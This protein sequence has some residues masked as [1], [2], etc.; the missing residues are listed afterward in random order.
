MKG[1]QSVLRS[2]IE[3]EKAGLDYCYGPEDR[4]RLQEML[5]EGNRKL[6]TNLYYL[7]E[8]DAYDLA[9]AGEIFCRY[10]DGFQSESVRAYLLPQIIADKVPGC[11]ALLLRLYRH[12]QSSPEFLPVNGRLPAHIYVRYDNAFRKRKPKKLEAELLTLAQDPV[13]FF[14]L[15]F[16]ME[17][18]ARW[19]A[20]SM[21]GLLLAYGSG[22]A[23]LPAAFRQGLSE[24][25]LAFA[26]RQIRFTVIACSSYFPTEAVAELV[27][28]FARQGDPDLCQA[29]EKA[30]RR[31][32]RMRRSGMETPKS[33]ALP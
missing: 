27:E 7:A 6:G 1:M 16:T 24:R 19:R 22:K 10:I 31:A 18:L 30:R 15:P 33:C 32:W 3:R 12:F 23:Q 4:E 9:G 11:D 2:S 20:P 29:V 8:I 13:S 26:E 17:L 5:E 14:Y 21:A 28:G 25:Q